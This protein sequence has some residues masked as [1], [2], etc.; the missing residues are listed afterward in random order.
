MGV[1]GKN[2][3]GGPENKKKNFWQRLKELKVGK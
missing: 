1:G 2:T 3:G